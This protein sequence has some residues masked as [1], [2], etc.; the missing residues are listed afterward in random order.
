[1][2]TAR[3]TRRRRADVE[4]LHAKI[5]ELMLIIRRAHQDRT[6]EEREEMIDWNHELSISRQ[7]KALGVCRRGVYYLPQSASAVDL[8]LRRRIDES[9]LG[10]PFAGSRMPRGF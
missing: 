7:A 6:V 10:Y 2:I 5:G 3:E 1:M 4:S 9:H 8:A